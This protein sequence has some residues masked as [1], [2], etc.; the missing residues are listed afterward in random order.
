MNAWAQAAMI[1]A[2]IGMDLFK[3]QNE[4][5][6]QKKMAQNQIQWRVADAKKAGIHPLYALGAAPMHYSS[7]VGT[8]STRFQEFGQDLT[9]SRL[10][11]Q[12]AQQ[13]KAELARQAV[14]DALV[15]ERTRV[16]IDGQRLE[17]KLLQSQIARLNSAQI[18]PAAPVNP[19]FRAEPE[20]GP[21][22]QPRPS[23]PIVGASGNPARQPGVITDYQFFSYPDGSLG[24][25][26]SEEMKQRI[27]DNLPQ[28]VGWWFRNNVL[29]AFNPP[30]RPN[31]R[32]YPLPPGYDVWEWDRVFQRYR[33]AR[34]SSWR[35]QRGNRRW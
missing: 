4:W 23:E 9:R 5:K 28:E 32:D 8:D 30:P 15:Q 29:T 22:V 20:A 13:R 33:P 14:N 21:R 18:G 31:T 2:D 35:S 24:V 27:E 25:V 16:E 3:S 12:D 17:N 1:G 19:A 6:K 10:A 26:P 7:S 34:R 11:A